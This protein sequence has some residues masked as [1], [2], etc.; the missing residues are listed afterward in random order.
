MERFVVTFF[1]F[2]FHSFRH[3]FPHR[4]AFF[5]RWIKLYVAVELKFF[6]CR[7]YEIPMNNFKFHL[8]SGVQQGSIHGESK[9]AQSRKAII[10][11]L[12]KE[13]LRKHSEFTTF[14]R[15]KLSAPI[16]SFVLCS[17]F[18][19]EQHKLLFLSSNYFKRNSRLTIKLFVFRFDLTFTSL[20]WLKSFIDVSMDP[21]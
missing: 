15:K 4:V 10:R 8:L 18:W 9:Q 7:W 5:F 3:V 12:G 2:L 20:L 1:L 11:M 6:F 19:C 16:K 21:S 17:L 14:R 13:M